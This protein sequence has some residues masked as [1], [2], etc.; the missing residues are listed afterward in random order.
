M[1]MR[2]LDGKV[3]MVA[4]ATPGIGLTRERRARQDRGS[5]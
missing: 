1:E 5:T 3:L 4:G 2:R